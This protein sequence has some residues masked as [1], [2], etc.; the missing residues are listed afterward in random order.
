MDHIDKNKANN[1]IDNLRCI[2]INENRRNRD[3]TNIV[4]IACK[5]HAMK[6]FIKASYVDT[7]K[8]LYC[9][10]KNQ[11]AKYMGISPALVYLICE[12]KNNCKTANTEKG[13]VRFEYIDEKD[14]V[15]LTLIPHGRL[16]KTY[17]K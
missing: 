15:Q 12:G 17:K 9:N 2:T 13:K 11:C 3:H 8:V 10:C 14:V 16:G 1:R 5:A 7:D 6:I 4:K